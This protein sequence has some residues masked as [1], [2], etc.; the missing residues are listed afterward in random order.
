MAPLTCKTESVYH[1]VLGRGHISSSLTL[2]IST[3]EVFAPLVSQAS[4]CAASLE[5]SG[6]GA[7]VTLSLG[8]V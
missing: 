6:K 1:P 2:E 3:S 8:G 7:A 5:M 4:V